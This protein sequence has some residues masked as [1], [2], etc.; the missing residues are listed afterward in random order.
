MATDNPLYKLVL[1]MLGVLGI[2]CN[3]F[4][5]AP[6]A[7]AALITL[8]GG[9]EDGFTGGT[10]IASPSAELDAILSAFGG[11]VPFDFVSHDTQVAHTFTGLSNDIIGATLEFR[12]RG[13][14]GSGINT[15]GLIISFVDSDTIDYLDDI[16]YARPFGSL[17]VGGSILKAPDPGFLTPDEIWSSSS[18]ETIS[19]DL[20]SLLLNPDSGG[21]ALDLIPLLNSNGFMDVTFSDDSEVDFVRLTLETID[22]PEPS[23]DVSEPSSLL[24]IVFG[25]AGL[26]LVLLEKI[27]INKV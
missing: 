27:R 8:T 26:A 1:K 16:V 25:L 20:S 18:D 11:T 10:D 2:T 21:G 9:V 19:L 3:F 22:T 6:M 15:D 23:I 12:V 13:G 17:E 24:L 7:N 14:F 5:F 4:I